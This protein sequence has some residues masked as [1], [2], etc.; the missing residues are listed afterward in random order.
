MREADTREIEH[1]LAL[2]NSVTA[3]IASAAPEPQPGA[4]DP[5][6]D[7]FDDDFPEAPTPA[8]AATSTA[9]IIEEAAE[10]SKHAGGNG[11]GDRD[12]HQDFTRPTIEEAPRSEPLTL[13]NE[14]AEIATLGAVLQ[15]PQALRLVLAI[16][17]PADFY[18]AAHQRILEAAVA[19]S[20][21]GESPDL[22][23]LTE[24]LRSR[25]ALERCG[26]AAYVSRLTSGIPTS[27][28]V[29]YYARI[30]QEY[31]Q[32]RA[33]DVTLHQAL[34]ENISPT[35]PA[36]EIIARVSLQL[37]G[38]MSSAVGPRMRSVGD[39]F[40]YP[41]PQWQIEGLFE[42]NSL[43][44]LSALSGMGKTLTVYEVIRSLFDGFPAFGCSAFRVKEQGPVLLV[45]EESP[46]PV[47]KTR[48][49]RMKF[50]ETMPLSIL[51]FAGLRVDEDAGFAAIQQLIEN[52]K[53]ALVVFDSLIRM[54]SAEENSST[55]M[56]RVMRRFRLLSNM[57]TV[58]LI[59]HSGKAEQDPRRLSRGSGDIVAAVD[60]ELVLTR[61]GEELV[62]QSA[63]TRGVPLAP[64]RLKIISENEELGV[65]YLGQVDRERDQVVAAVRKA[66]TG[67][68]LGVMEIV[69]ELAK[70]GID[71]SRQ[72]VLT[73]LGKM[74]GEITIGVVPGGKGK[75]LYSCPGVQEVSK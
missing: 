57:A 13:H 17:R 14:E 51:H 18:L 65:R 30:V 42:R 70:E 38:F 27:A 47:L 23:T 31:S 28:N 59:H 46:R 9:E 33:F 8:E 10:Q 44:L 56:A 2:A 49:Q 53:P 45:D 26:G 39:V 43:N 11:Q 69:A 35:T 64:V 16:V 3:D 36:A 41:D 40:A 58:L 67:R 66:I 71:K 61:D 4:A 75:K 37:S 12:N 72:V 63:K 1:L 25:G 73:A 24:E 7:D 74:K 50:I 48:L 19:L 32:K 22:I 52:R 68:A 34:E 29:E 54:H 15:D 20:E 6:P 5:P 60:Q 62:L 55:E 21:R